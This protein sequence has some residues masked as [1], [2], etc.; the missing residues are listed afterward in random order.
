MAVFNVLPLSLTPFT[1]TTFCACSTWCF[2]LSF[3]N[4]VKLGKPLIVFVAE[5]FAFLKFS[6][7]FKA[8]F[9]L[10]TAFNALSTSALDVLPPVCLFKMPSAAVTACVYAF[11]FDSSASR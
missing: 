11:R 7:P 4:C 9:A 6:A 10:V 1:P 2:K 5:V 3:C 8:A